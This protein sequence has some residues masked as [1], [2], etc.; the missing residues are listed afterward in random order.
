MFGALSSSVWLGQ[1]VCKGVTEG[2]LRGE[3]GELGRAVALIWARLAQ[4]DSPPP[5]TVSYL[6]RLSV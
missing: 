5:P 4:R 3:A 6:A 2:A 1:R